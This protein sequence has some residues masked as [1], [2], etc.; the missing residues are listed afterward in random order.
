MNAVIT[1]GN[2]I[3]KALETLMIEHTSF[4]DA[5][6]VLQPRVRDTFAGF[7]PC[8]EVLIG[9]SRCGKTEVLKVIARD[10]PEIQNGGRR[11]IPL[12]VV[13]I[14]SSTTPKDLPLAVIRALGLPAPRHSMKV[15]ELNSYMLTQLRLANVRVILFDEASHLVDVG[16]RIPPRAASDWF[17]DLQANA[18]DIGIVL[19][20]VPRLKRLPDSNEQLRNRSRK[21]ISLM[22]YR[23]DDESQRKSFAGCVAAFLQEFLS[24][25]CELG[26]PFNTFTRHCYAVSAGQVGLLAN[27]FTELSIQLGDQ[28]QLTY[29]VCA[30]ASANLNLPGNKIVL[31]FVKEELTDIELMQVLVSE[32]AVYDL[33]LPPNTAETE[34]AQARVNAASIARKLVK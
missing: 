19:T 18:R 2:E 16:T 13:Y 21:P 26:M 4:M 32:L 27:F 7:L 12:L 9:L 20:G 34:L 23:W 29:A 24:R 3:R 22:P 17:K 30:D 33:V 15:G 31:P 6:K 14:T 28:R 10:Y 8:F 5:L 1:T 25:G 11:E